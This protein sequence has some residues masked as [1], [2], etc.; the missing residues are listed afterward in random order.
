MI[1][2][3]VDISVLDYFDF[4]FKGLQINFHKLILKGITK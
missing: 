4:I 3:S 1:H 2:K